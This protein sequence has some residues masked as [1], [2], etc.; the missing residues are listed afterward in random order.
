[1]MVGPQQ[2]PQIRDP[3][4]KQKKRKRRKKKANRAIS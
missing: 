4:L 2:N 3:L 1:M